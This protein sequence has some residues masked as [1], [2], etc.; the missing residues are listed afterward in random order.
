LIATARRVAALRPALWAEASEIRQEWLE[1]GLSTS[2]ADRAR[3]EEAISS[4]YA[5]HRRGRPS[6]VWLPSP[7]AAVPHLGELPTHRTLRS[8]I[9]DRRPPGK[10]PIAGDLAA[11]LSRLRSAFA[12]TYD[13]PP[14]D[15]PAL[16]RPKGKPWPTLPPERALEAGLP[17]HEILRQGVYESLFRTLT[18]EIC[19]PIRAAA[20]PAATPARDLLPVGWFGHQ[21]AAWIAHLDVLRRLKLASAPPAF[22]DW[23]TL[24]HAG[25][26]WWPGERECVLVERPVVLRTTPLTIKYPDGWSM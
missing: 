17:F 23:V 12:A 21:D 20:F 7:A 26:W 2:P 3:T 25:G 14:A 18:T 19:N 22:D 15:R 11:G 16:Q 4:L 1:I 10:P 5:G 9:S 24:A 8:W 6:F 13:E